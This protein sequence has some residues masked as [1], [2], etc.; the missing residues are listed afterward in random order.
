MKKQNRV[1]EDKYSEGRELLHRP[2]MPL[3]AMLRFLFMTGPFSRIADVI[4][5]L[6][7]PIVTDQ[8]TYAAPRALLHEYSDILAG[9]EDLKNGSGQRPPV[10]DEQGGSVDAF[11]A[12][13]SLIVQEVLARELERINSVL[14]SPCGCILCCVGPA[15]DMAQEFFEIPLAEDELDLFPVSRLDSAESRCRSSDGEDELTCGGRPFYRAGAPGLFHWRTGWSLILPEDSACPNLDVAGRCLIYEERPRVCRRPQLFP[16]MVEPLENETAA[17]P[18]FRLRRALLAVLDCPYV[19]DLRE[20]ITVY[21]A[22]SELHLVLKH[23]K[24]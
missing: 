17:G 6:P 20:D 4:G 5:E 24:C 12:A 8:A 1:A 3:V 16:Y 15:G 21:A 14:C 19:R 9:Y 22:A 13:D 2:V 18:A 10:V 7:E 23:N 11:T